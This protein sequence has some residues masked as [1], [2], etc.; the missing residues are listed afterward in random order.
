[1]SRSGSTPIRN[2]TSIS[3]FAHASRICWV[4]R[5]PSDG[6]LPHDPSTS[7]RSVS[8]GHAATAGQE[9]RVDPGAQGP[10]VAGA[11]RHERHATSVLLGDGQRDVGGQRVLRRDVRRSGARRRRRPRA[12]RRRPGPRTCPPGHRRRGSAPARTS[13]VRG[14]RARARRRPTGA[15]GADGSRTR[16]R[17]CARPCGSAGAGSAPPARRPGPRRGSTF[18]RSTSR[19]GRRRAATRRRAARRGRR[20]QRPAMVEVVGPEPHAREL[21]QRVR[22]LV[23]EPPAGEER[24]APGAATTRRCWRTPRR[25]TR[26]SSP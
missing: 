25:T 11:T 7:A 8:L 20:G 12:A 13:G 10:A 23:G 18:A 14:G 24:D 17:R 2:R 15:S 19:V 21:G 9:R 26:G 16:R 5:P 3:R 22:V 4:E 1:M 6:R